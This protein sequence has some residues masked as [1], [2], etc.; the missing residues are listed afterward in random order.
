MS[1]QGK[2]VLILDD[3]ADFR[4]FFEKVLST[5]GMKATTAATVAQAIELAE[6]RA[7]H[8]LL[9]DLNMPGETGF[10]LL[11]RRRETPALLRIPTI[12]VSGLRDRNSVYRAMALGAN[13]Y[14]TKPVAVNLLLQKLRKAFHEKDFLKVEFKPGAR[15]RATVGVKC[16][17]KSIAETAVFMVSTAKIAPQ[18]TI[19][20]HA[21]ALS[22]TGLENCVALTHKTPP[23]LISANQYGV[24]ANV[25]GLSKENIEKIRE[26]MESWRWQKL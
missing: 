2:E 6:K 8:L 25:A 4:M 1:L 21:A 3:D 11:E 15:L 13:D 24:Y 5:V 7:P 20:L 9:T 12:V 14:I 18:T 10:D 23:Y 22:G 19:A 26:L 17:I 16:N